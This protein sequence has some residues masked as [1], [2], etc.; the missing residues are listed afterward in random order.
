MARNL[1]FFAAMLALGLFLDSNKGY[2]VLAIACFVVSGMYLEA[3]LIR[4][5]HAW[6]IATNRQR[7][8]DELRQ[9]E[10]DQ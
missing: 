8:R 5:L 3:A 9:R 7:L 4:F 2:P 6:S 10:R 1:I